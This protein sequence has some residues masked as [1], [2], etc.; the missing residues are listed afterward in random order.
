MHANRR[1]VGLF[2]VAGVE[3]EE[4]Q[5]SPDSETVDFILNWTRNGMSRQLADHDALERRS[6]Q[7]FAAAAVV[8]GLA[9][10]CPDSGIPL[11]PPP[12]Y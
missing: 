1:H 11:P 7:T 6:A 4:P 8:V 2:D 3:A 9:Q 5:V 10:V 12:C